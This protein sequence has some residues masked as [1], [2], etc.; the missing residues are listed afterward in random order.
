MTG[1]F[2]LCQD[3]RFYLW[4]SWFSGLLLASA[5]DELGIKACLRCWFHCWVLCLCYWSICPDVADEKAKCHNSLAGGQI[6]QYLTNCICICLLTQQSHFLEFALC[7]RR[8][9]QEIIHCRII[10]NCKILETT[11]V[12]KN[13]RL[14]EHTVTCTQCSSVGMYGCKKRMWKTSVK[15]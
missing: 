5:N 7:I 6:W 12:F 2:L 10:C 9:M 8:Y 14:V 3:W 11:S 13:R 4:F 15:Q 1:T